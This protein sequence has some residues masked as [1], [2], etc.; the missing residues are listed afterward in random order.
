MHFSHNASFIHLSSWLLSNGHLV[1]KFSAFNKTM[2]RL[3]KQGKTLKSFTY[4]N[5]EIADDI[6]AA[7][8]ST[9]FTGVSVST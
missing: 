5:K 9:Q 2:G 8:N 7:I 3:K 4:T 6:Y 1:S